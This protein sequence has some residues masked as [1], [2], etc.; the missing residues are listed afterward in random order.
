MLFIY[1]LP[2]MVNK[3]FQKQPDNKYTQEIRS[4]QCYI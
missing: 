3:E 1:N 4:L 2:V